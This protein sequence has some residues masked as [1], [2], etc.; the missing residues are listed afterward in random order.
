MV[1]IESG[2]RMTENKPFFHG[3]STIFLI[4]LISISKVLNLRYI[5]FE[6]N[7]YSVIDNI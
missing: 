5:Y 2:F 7:I 4:Y 3:F 1:D 6:S